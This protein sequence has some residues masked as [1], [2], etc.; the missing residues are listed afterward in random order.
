VNWRESFLT[1][2]HSAASVG[3]LPSW[4]T[5]NY[6]ATMALSSYPC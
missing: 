5:D 6:V 1:L 4:D 2:H 3:G